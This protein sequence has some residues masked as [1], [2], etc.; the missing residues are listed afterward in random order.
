MTILEVRK[1]IPDD[2]TEVHGSAQ[3]AL[4]HNNVD[5]LNLRIYNYAKIN[6]VVS[7]SLMLHIKAERGPLVLEIRGGVQDVMKTGQ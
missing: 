5:D 6:F 3:L 4:S 7:I 1:G 2:H